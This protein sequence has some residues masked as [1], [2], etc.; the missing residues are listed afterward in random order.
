MLPFTDADLKTEISAKI[1][2]LQ[3]FMERNRCAAILLTQV[4]NF[5]WLTGGVGD[6]QVGR[7]S[8]VGAASL[9]LAKDG[10]KF[11]IAA[12][13]EIPRLIEDGLGG[14]GY[15]PVELKWY[16][17]QPDLAKLLGLSGT[18]GSDVEREGCTVVNIAPLRYQ[19]SPAEILKY[20]WLGRDCAEAVELVTRQVAPGMTEHHIEAQIANALMQRGVRP[21]VLLIGADDRIMRFRHALPSDRAVEK[22]A[23]VNI[24]GKKWGL[25]ASVTRFVHFGPLDSELKKR[26]HAAAVVNSKYAHALRPGAKISGIFQQATEWYAELGYPGEWTFHHQGG[27]TGYNERE[28]VI[29]PDSTEVVL[30]HQAFAMNP[31]VQGAKAEDTILVQQDHTENLSSTPN[32]PKINVELDGRVYESADVLIQGAEQTKW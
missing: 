6:N 12:H 10:R 15:E 26:L 25:T 17:K 1:S 3:A 11:V 22:Y 16:E 8:E 4:R 5:E 27:A 7:A 19:L 2:R 18:L 20:R 24:C 13:S 31:T 30:D 23:M 29:T 21:T 32:W 14:L 28:Y 9:L